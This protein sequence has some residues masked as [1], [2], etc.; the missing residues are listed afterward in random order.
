MNFDIR[1]KTS[2]HLFTLRVRITLAPSSSLPLSCQNID[3]S[4]L[5]PL[6]Q[7]VPTIDGQTEWLDDM[8]M[9]V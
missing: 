7:P 2:M 3:S 6:W 5:K 1:A 8:M 9:V 4:S